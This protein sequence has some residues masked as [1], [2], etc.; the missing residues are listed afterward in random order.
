[1][2]FGHTIVTFRYLQISLPRLAP[3]TYLET[4]NVLAV[5]LAA[6]MGRGLRGAKRAAL[7]VACL[8]RL[9]A[10]GRSGEVDPA[11]VD[12]LADVVETYLATGPKER[13][14]LRLQL[15][16]QGGDTVKMEATE[17]TWRSRVEIEIRR[18]DIKRAVRVRFGHIAPEVEAVINTAEYDDEL[19]ALF[20]RAVLAQTETDL[21][22]SAHP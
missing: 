21:L 20:D 15:K 10:V 13:T 6:V 18:E 4:G 22:P 5:A 8:Q 14:A 19:D 3:Y 11:T 1:M 7:Y 16:R 2:L 17:L 9:I 12:L